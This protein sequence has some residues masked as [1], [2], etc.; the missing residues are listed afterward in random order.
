[1]APTRRLSFR[2]SWPRLVLWGLCLAA[3]VWLLLQSDEAPSDADR[4]A[5]DTP[6][7][8]VPADDTPSD[9]GGP[10]RFGVLNRTAHLIPLWGLGT[11]LC[12]AAAALH[13]ERDGIR[14]D[15]FED[16]AALRDALRAGRLDL[17]CVPLRDALLLQFELDDAA[18]KVIAGAA[19]GDEQFVLGR[20]LTSLPIGDLGDYRAAL[21]ETA[22]LDVARCLELGADRAPEVVPAKADN[23][24]ELLAQGR[25]DFALLPGP[26][27]D[28]A[29]ATSGSH[30]A[31]PD[32]LAPDGTCIQG[33]AV[34]V[35][36]PRFLDAE[37][38]LVGL[39]LQQ[40]ELAAQVVA[41]DTAQAA[42][43]AAGVVR[44]AGRE[45]PP[46]VIWSKSVERIRLGTDI[47]REELL[48]LAADARALGMD[49]PDAA[50][51][52]LV[53]AARLE[54]ARRDVAETLAEK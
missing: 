32:D 5:K 49:L 16:A 21:V 12:Y 41:S 36:A 20:D 2:P 35:A 26:L 10:I 23:V 7:A 29:A 9:P 42:A 15:V 8:A 13:S 44:R 52:R 1:M 33:G 11:E 4:T 22:A 43:V 46:D 31:A 53:D 39:L 24:S 19:L 17:A 40:H 38:E 30:V 6:A 34:L 27:A 54:Q 18:P 50:V 14:A 28:A 47:P 25:A 3:V 48:R 37:P 45:T 51:E